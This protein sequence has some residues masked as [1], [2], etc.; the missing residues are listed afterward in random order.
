M[1]KMGMLIQNTNASYAQYAAYQQQQQQQVKASQLSGAA[2][3]LSGDMLL[4][5][6]SPSASCGG[7]GRK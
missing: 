7:C 6:N 1:A 2:R 4:R 5:V 3:R